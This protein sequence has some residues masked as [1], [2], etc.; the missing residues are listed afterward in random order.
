MYYFISCNENFTA[1]TNYYLQLKTLNT[2]VQLYCNLVDIASLRITIIA[3]VLV[4]SAICSYATLPLVQ[5]YA[6]VQSIN[7]CNFTLE[8]HNILPILIICY[9]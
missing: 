6:P 5:D 4:S 2:T 3:S 8:I 1:A 9:V 7:L